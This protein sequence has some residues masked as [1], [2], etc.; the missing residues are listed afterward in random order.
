MTF[1]TGELEGKSMADWAAA[2]ESGEPRLFIVDYW[3]VYGLLDTIAVAMQGRKSAM[4]AGR[5]ILF[6]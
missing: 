6:R 4:H 2:G 5:C 3:A 1:A